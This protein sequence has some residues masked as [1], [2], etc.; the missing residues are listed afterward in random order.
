MAI[1]ATYFSKD[2]NERSEVLE[3]LERK[4]KVKDDQFM[5]EI[6]SKVAATIFMNEN[7]WESALNS[8]AK[9]VKND[10]ELMSFA[11]VIYLKINRLDLA[12]KQFQEMQLK[13]DDA[14]LTQLAQAWIH[15]S[16][17]STL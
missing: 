2:V 10:L 13:D 11:V 14:T 17:V 6:G 1:L 3:E 8:I 4:I 5:N 16:S 15:V 12:Q 9:F 7:H